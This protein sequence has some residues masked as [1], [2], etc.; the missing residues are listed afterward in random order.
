MVELSYPNKWKN[1]F[2]RID[3]EDNLVSHLQNM[4]GSLSNQHCA[5]C[6]HRIMESI[7]LL[8]FPVLVITINWS[9]LVF[10][11]TL[12]LATFTI[13]ILE[14]IS[15]VVIS[16]SKKSWTAASTVFLFSYLLRGQS[17]DII[18]ELDNLQQAVK[19]NWLRQRNPL[20][21]C[22]YSHNNEH[23]IRSQ[24]HI[25]FKTQISNLVF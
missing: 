16:E 9:I 25:S 7:N 1:I 15:K 24:R 22:C 17:P 19:V 10:S 18:R 4:K 21:D 5:V 11:L 6:V 23:L 13:L 2:P 20:L 12:Q 3:I 14:L 8:N